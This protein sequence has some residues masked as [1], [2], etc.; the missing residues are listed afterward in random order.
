MKGFSKEIKI[1][2]TAILSIIIIY[3]GIIFLKGIKM[4]GN[5]NIYLV[6]INDISG[7]TVSSEVTVNGMNIGYVKDIKYNQEKQNLIVAIDIKEGFIIPEGSTASIAK[8]MLG[9]TK[10]NLILGKNTNK[11]ITNNDTIKGKNSVDLMASAAE[12]IPQIQSIMP[13]VDSILTSLNNILSDASINKS[14][15]N[16]EY[17]TYNLRSTTDNFNNIM[18]KDLPVL[19]SKANNICNNVEILTNNINKMDFN[20]LMTNANCTMQNLQVFTNRL[21]SKDNSLGLLLND[22]QIYNNLD[23]TIQNASLLLQDIR[24]NPKKYVHF[25][26]IGKK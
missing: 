15:E 11:A 22:K 25:S 2:I 4:F 7:L 16:I 8:E 26:L 1:A 17:I 10:M 24:I 13:K 18:N 21:N 12:M 14:I 9:N 3:T 6:E 19:L 5:E 20:S 23:S